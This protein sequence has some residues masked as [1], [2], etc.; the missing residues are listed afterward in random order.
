MVFLPPFRRSITWPYTPVLACCSHTQRLSWT[1][2]S[3][4]ATRG[5]RVVVRMGSFEESTEG[6]TSPPDYQP[7]SSVSSTHRPPAAR[8]TP[9][10]SQCQFEWAKPDLSPGTP[11]HFARIYNS[12]DAYKGLRDRKQQFLKG[13]ADLNRHR[14]NYG[15]AGIQPSCSWALDF[16]LDRMGR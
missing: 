6:S 14:A 15:P 1:T 10:N 2:F 16:A 3:Y 13:L 7:S 12:I 11:W 5:R 4:L 9:T 8:S